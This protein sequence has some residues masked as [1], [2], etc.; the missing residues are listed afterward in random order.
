MLAAQLSSLAA[1]RATTGA[2]AAADAS[3]NAGAW[4]GAG[5]GAAGP[6]EVRKRK[7]QSPGDQS[8][9]GGGAEEATAVASARTASERLAGSARELQAASERLARAE[10]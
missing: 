4:A 9:G 10:L 1:Q 5:T 3:V 6:P 8:G 2:T 7:G